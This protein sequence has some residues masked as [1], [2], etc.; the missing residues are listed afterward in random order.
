MFENIILTGILQGLI[1]SFVAYGIMIPF[2]IVNFA[3]LTAEGSYPFA[4]AICAQLILYNINPFLSIIIAALCAGCIGLTTALVHLKLK[5]NSLLSGIIVSTMLYSISLRIL[6]RPNIALFNQ[7]LIFNSE[8]S[9]MQKILFILIAII[10]TI[11]LLNTFLK[12]EIGLR[13]RAIGFN[14]DFASK[15][16]ISIIKYTLIG[17]FIANCYTGIGA[18]LMVQNQNYVDISMGIGIVLNALAALMIGENI[19]SDKNIILAPLVGSIIY[20]LIQG[21]ALFAGL[22][23]SDLK[24]MTGAMIL[25]VISLNNKKNL[26]PVF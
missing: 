23:P 24:F 13:L 14:K 1:L 7:Q 8:M 17:L 11:I 2:R 9:I 20:Q 4:G 18:C 6:N 21:L 22:E 5:V 16:N 15:Q 3:D 25:A 10:I 26:K 19:I 12:T